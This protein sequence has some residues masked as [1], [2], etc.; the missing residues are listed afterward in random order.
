LEGILGGLT[1]LVEKLGELSEK[2]ETLSRTGGFEWG[3]GGKERKGVFG[4]SVKTVLGGD[5][6]AVEPFGNIR[7]DE[8]SGETV[9]QEMREPVVDVFEEGDHTLIV[10]EMPGI[11]VDDVRLEVRDD[12]LTIQAEKGDMKYRK[13]VLLPQSHPREKM[14]VSCNNGIL[15]IKCRV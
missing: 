12:V 4:F 10:A 5:E 2:G 15:E 3:E 1:D 13:E 8:E 7:R 6:V 11:G 14:D 9:V